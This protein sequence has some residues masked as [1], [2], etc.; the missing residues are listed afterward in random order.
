MQR[1]YTCKPQHVLVYK[2]LGTS[3]VSTSEVSTSKVSTSIHLWQQRLGKHHR[4]PNE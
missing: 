2:K 3:K 4:P 1:L